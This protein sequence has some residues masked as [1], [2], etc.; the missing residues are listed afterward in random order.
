MK[1][2]ASCLRQKKNMINKKRYLFRI[3]IPAF[4]SFNIYTGIAKRT[5]ALGPI[6]V[7]TSANKLEKWDV[8]VID[9]NN[10]ASKFCPK[11]ELGR[12][13]HREL[14]KDRPADVIG[15]YG[16]LTSTIPRLY[17]LAGLYK[18]FGAKTIAG[19]KHIENLPKEALRNNIDAVVFGDGEETI[20]KVL[21]AWQRGKNLEKVAGIAFLNSERKIVKTEERKLIKDFEK[22]PLSDFNLLRYAKMKTYPISWWRGCPHN[23]EFCAVKDK[24]R[25]VPA[26][27]LASIVAHLVETRKA[28][29]FFIVD[30]H[31][32]GNHYDKRQR[33]EAIRF[34]RLIA[35]YKNRVKKRISFT[36]QIRLTAA[37]HPELL[38]AMREAGV[39][40]VCIGYESPIDEELIA[41]RKGFLSKQMIELTKIFHRFG[42]FIHGMFIF[43]YPQKK[44]VSGAGASLPI[45]GRIKRF[46]QFI[47]KAKIDTVQVLLTVPLPG[48]ELS[49]RLRKEGRLYPLRQIGWE[50]YDGQF[51]L[52]EP[53]DGISPEELQ[54]AVKKIMRGFYRFNHIFKIIANIL[55]HFPRIVFP[56]SFTLLTL[57]VRYLTAAFRRWRR[58]YFRNQTLR[59]G[60]Y[61]V[62]KG[63]I[64][65]FNEGNFLLKLERAKVQTKAVA[66]KD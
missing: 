29:S 54:Q 51:P 7:A 13:D 33:E 30:D 12:P 1:P 57:R 5:T 53:D 63:W 24:T 43:G 41:M 9:E 48:T 8:E 15:F 10:C 19:G 21:L 64:K 50:Y 11:D 20:K 25:C 6:L 40:M 2:S 52:F 42:F 36:V 3:V 32:G 26:E 60:G 27:R 49:K 17:E 55:F 18:K 45:E 61:L 44:G 23:C 37:R 39:S 58:L 16:S 65:K 4:P 66:L 31:F 28:K 22:M 38:Q 35:E 62:V 34:C 14:Q 46:Y 59:F 47:S 56:A